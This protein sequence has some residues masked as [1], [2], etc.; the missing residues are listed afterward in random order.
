MDTAA[1]TW[2]GTAP[3]RRRAPI[4]DSSFC[5]SSLIRRTCTR[6]DSSPT[7]S[8][9]RLDAV[10]ELLAVARLAQLGETRDRVAVGRLGR[11]VEQ[12]EQPALDGLAHHVLPAARLLVHQLPVEPDHVGEQPLGQAV[13]AHHPHGQAVPLA[14]ELQVAVTLD[15]EQPVA[16]HPG[17]RLAHRRAALVQPLGDPCAQGDDALLLELVD[18]AEVHLGGVDQV[19]HRVHCCP[20]RHRRCRVWRM[21]DT[22][23]VPARYCGPAASGNGG[24]VAAP[25]PTSSATPSGRAVTVTL[26]QPPPLDAT[27]HVNP[28]RRRAHADLRRRAS[29]PRPSRPSRTSSRSRGS[30]GT[31]RWP[32]ARRTPDTGRTRSRSASPAAPSARTGCGSSPAWCRP[33]VGTAPGWRRRG[34]PTA[35]W[36][37]TTTSTTTPRRARAWPRPGRRWTASAAGP[38]TS[39]SG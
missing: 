10:A 4:S 35:R 36:P 3:A 37:P 14:G 9:Q 28:R 20:W 26:R 25:W 8:E 33:C 30:R 2:P 7:T 29:W 12:L 34:S 24:Y 23:L 17:D 27:M 15:G 22:L 38:A 1:I 21:K 16:L 39:P 32:R 6:T 18:G 11:V 31:R 5:I 13:L 19:A